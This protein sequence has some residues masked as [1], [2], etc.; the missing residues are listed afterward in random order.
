MTFRSGLFP[1][2]FVLWVVKD[3]SCSFQLLNCLI[4]NKSSHFFQFPKVPGNGSEWIIQGNSLVSQWTLTFPHVSLITL[5]KV[6]FFGKYSPNNWTCTLKHP[7]FFSRRNVPLRSSL[8]NAATHTLDAS[9]LKFWNLGT[10]L[11]WRCM[12]Y[13]CSKISC[14]LNFFCYQ[15]NSIYWKNW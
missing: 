9:E 8:R 7:V 1:V 2:Q 3:L 6:L 12:L 5:E 10:L 14:H 15:I 11:C 13:Y 4:V